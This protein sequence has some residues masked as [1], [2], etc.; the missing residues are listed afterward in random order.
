MILF[1]LK[2]TYH[3]LLGYYTNKRMITPQISTNRI[4]TKIKMCDFQVNKSCILTFPSKRNKK[5]CILTKSCWICLKICYKWSCYTDVAAYVSLLQFC[6]R[7]LHSVTN[8]NHIMVATQFNKIIF[9]AELEYRGL[10][11][12][13]EHLLCG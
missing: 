2:E 5:N 4:L 10:I 6:E 7:L 9:S 13:I 3:L 1:S 8:Y 12:S 11:N